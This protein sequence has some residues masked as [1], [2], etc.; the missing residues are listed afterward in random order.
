MS[1]GDAIR[2]RSRRLADVLG[3]PVGQRLAVLGAE[4]GAHLRAVHLLTGAGRAPVFSTWPRL[5]ELV[6]RRARTRM[7]SSVSSRSRSRS[8]GA[9]RSRRSSSSIPSSTASP[10][11]TANLWCMRS[12]IPA[13]PRV[14][15]RKRLDRLGPRLRRRRDRDRPGVGDVVERAGRRPRAGRAER[16]EA[17]TS[18]T[19]VGLEAD[20]VHR[21]VEA[22]LR[23]ARGSR[24]AGVRCRRHAGRR[25]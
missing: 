17:S 18:A 10:S 13:T 9:S 21:E 5:P 15:D 19:G 23:L 6:E 12:G 11:R 14:V 1:T 24:R 3:H 20:V 25:R 8:P 4:P 2:T 16:S 22:P 7:R